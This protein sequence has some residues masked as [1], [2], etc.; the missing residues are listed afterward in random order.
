MET[1]D[2]SSVSFQSTWPEAPHPLKSTPSSARVSSVGVVL[3]ALAPVSAVN[4]FF[5]L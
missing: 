5:G 4:V 2:S 1:S 3:P